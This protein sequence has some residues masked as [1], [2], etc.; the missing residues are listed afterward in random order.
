MILIYVF[1]YLNIRVSPARNTSFRALK[2]VYWL[3]HIRILI[4]HH[5]YFIDGQHVAQA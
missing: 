2:C 5:P 1:P 4:L 3:A